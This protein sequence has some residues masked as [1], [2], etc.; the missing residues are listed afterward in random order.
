MLPLDSLASFRALFESGVAIGML[1]SD[2]F[3]F[4]FNRRFYSF[5]AFRS[6]L[7]LAADV[8][9]LPTMTCIRELGTIR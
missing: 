6:L 2:E 5:N 8:E 7:G 9:G 1:A 3:T 4:R